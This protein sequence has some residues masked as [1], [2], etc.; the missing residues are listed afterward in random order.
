MV[1]YLHAM[2]VIT[3]LAL[4]SSSHR[5]SVGLGGTPRQ[6]QT[7]AKKANKYKYTCISIVNCERKITYIK[8]RI[9]SI[10]CM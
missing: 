9:Q 8:Y 4:L 3:P 7:N 6:L 10:V 5:R 2:F 1:E